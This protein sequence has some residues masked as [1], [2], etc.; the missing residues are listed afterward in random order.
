MPSVTIHLLIGN[1]A[2]RRLTLSPQEVTRGKGW[3]AH[4]GAER[5]PTALAPSRDQKTR[6]SPWNRS[7]SWA[8]R[9]GR[10][11]EA[12]EAPAAADI[13]APAFP[14]CLGTD[15]GQAPR[16]RTW[17]DSGASHPLPVPRRT[18]HAFSVI[19]E[20]NL[21]SPQN[22]RCPIACGILDPA[23][24]AAP[25]V[26][27]SR[28]TTAIQTSPRRRRAWARVEMACFETTSRP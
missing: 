3:D 15:R 14:S 20:H 9:L 18:Q 23:R 11:L 2:T 17:A 28:H 12:S 22:H 1:C 4:T 26:P 7:T 19:S 16:S 27:P 25:A 10:C 8:L 24:G 21:T 13:V 6:A 5:V